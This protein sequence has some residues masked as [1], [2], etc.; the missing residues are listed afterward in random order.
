MARTDG[1]RALTVTAGAT[2][3]AVVIYVLFAMAPIQWSAWRPAS[4]M[5]DG[6]FCEAVR[7]G[8]IR[9]PAN[10]ASGLIFLPAAAAVLAAASRRRRRLLPDHVGDPL[11]SQPIYVLLLGAVT[12]LIGL[13]T[14][15]YHA[16]LSFWG[17]TVDVLGM[18]LLAT[19]LLLFSATRMWTL[20]RRSVG[21]MY[22]L[23]NAVLLAGL[24]AVPQA[25]RYVFGLLV[26]G[27]IALEL[28]ARSRSRSA[29]SRRYFM[30]AVGVLL[31]GFTAWI[32]DIT[33]TWCSPMS[34]IQGH[35]F[36]HTCGAGAVVLIALHYL[37]GRHGPAS[38]R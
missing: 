20:D 10:T 11:V 35:A 23:G 19:L 16:S 32:L 4:C 7:E 37:S 2:A 15:F 9:Q 31:A 27:V 24:V 25:R 17:Q 38:D 14:A 30:A 21:L 8:S 5:P 28:A 6:C 13:G 18:Y 26:F 1:H 3:V 33:R 36:W 29:G 12:V 22:V 34:Y